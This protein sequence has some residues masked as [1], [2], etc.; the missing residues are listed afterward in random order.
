M[1]VSLLF[2]EGAARPESL[3]A[4][5]RDMLREDLKLNLV[6]DAVAAGDR[7]IRD[8]WDQA[9]FAPLQDKAL[10]EY[11]HEVLKDAETNTDAFWTLYEMCQEADRRHK[12]SLTT[13]NWMSNYDLMAT[14]HG[15]VAD[16]TAYI[17]TLRALRKLAEQYG[18]SFRSRGF[19]SLF[20]MLR[21]ELSEAY[22]EDVKRQLA[23]L[24]SLDA[25]VVSVRL[26]SY[27]QGVDYVL[28]RREKKLLDL[29]LAGAGTYKLGER[30]DPARDIG[31]RQARAVNELVNALGR[32]AV[33]LA[34]FFDTLRSELAFYG[35]CLIFSEGMRSRGM[36]V[37][38]PTI[39]DAGTDSRAWEELYDVSLVVLKRAA[40]TG[41]DLRSS[42][43]RLYL[44]TGANQGGKTTFLRS[45]GL[46][47]L[48]AQCGM[49]VGAASFAAPLRGAVYAHFK[50]E[51]D[52][53]MNSGK[54]DE[55]LVR[56]RK[57]TDFIRPGDLLLLNESF[58]S[59]SEREGSEMLRQVTQALLDSGV[60]I[61]SV[62][63]LH[64][65]AAA[66]LGREEVQFL[67]AQR[68]ESGKRTFRIQTGEPLETAYGE[69]LYRE[70]FG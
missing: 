12:G 48:M 60:E 6:L 30:D 3:P 63:H 19:L 25:F 33:Y 27:L 42:H 18:G 20:R 4:F 26:G 67:R 41:N 50:R 65:Y 59:T 66:F 17:Q 35:G 55:E 64:T 34:G 28:Q 44:I 21:E 56:M 45:L 22:L 36:P 31:A 46:A 43:K 49:P 53:W 1:N 62:S 37:C 57:I 61:F 40:V 29:A 2:P 68:L 8:A 7:D 23:E 70:V 10:I 13:V 24:S 52:R 16:L 9:V 58:S 69:D 51:E 5:S 32:S 39:T 14:F 47:Q 11:R 54:L 38:M 15:A